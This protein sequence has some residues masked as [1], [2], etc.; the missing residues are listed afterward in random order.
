MFKLLRIK[1]VSENSKELSRNLTADQKKE[2]AQKQ[3][4]K[5]VD[6]L[7]TT[8][9]SW[10]QPKTV[11][12][13]LPAHEKPVPIEP[14]PNERQRLPFKMTEEDRLRRKAW[15]HSQELTDREPVTVP[16]LERMIYN[17][18]R[19]LYRT[20][21]DKL[22]NLLAPAIGEHRVRATRTLVPKLFLA[23]LGGCYLW[24]NIKYNKTVGFFIKFFVSNKFYHFNIIERVGKKRKVLHFSKLEELFYQ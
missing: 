15:V 24:Y 22:F 12:D 13:N 23:Y 7:L 18:I 14:F 19:R 20:P 10:S 9:A 2:L 11:F 21:T 4:A 3:H 1:M 16:E 8:E 5:E 6:S 17:P